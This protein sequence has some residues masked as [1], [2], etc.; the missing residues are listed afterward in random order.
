MKYGG[1]EKV[2][3]NCIQSLYRIVWVRI[4][5]WHCTT[6]KHRIHRK[7]IVQHSNKNTKK[8]GIVIVT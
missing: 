3:E 7:Y 8:Y 1:Q 2:T 4:I 6:K 5:G